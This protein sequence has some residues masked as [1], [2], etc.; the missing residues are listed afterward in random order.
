MFKQ[1]RDDKKAAGRRSGGFAALFAAFVAAAFLVWPVAGLAEAAEIPGVPKSATGLVYLAPDKWLKNAVGKF[2]DVV[3]ADAKFSKVREEFQKNYRFPFPASAAAYVKDIEEIAVALVPEEKGPGII[4]SVLVTVKFG[5]TGTAASFYEKC[6]RRIVDINR[7]PAAG[8]AELA[9]LETVECGV[10][11]TTMVVRD[12]PKPPFVSGSVSPT[13]FFTLVHEDRFGFLF[14]PPKEKE[15]VSELYKSVAG[16]M[17]SGSQ[18][19][20]AAPKFQEAAARI[21]KIAPGF[22]FADGSLIGLPSVAGP[23]SSTRVFSWAAAGM[24][25][26]A[27]DS[28]AVYVRGVFRVDED[29]DRRQAA[30]VAAFKMLFAAQKQG[31]GTLPAALVPRDAVTLLNLRFRVSPETLSLPAFVAFARSF[32]MIPGMNFDSDVASW[33]NGDV[34]ISVDDYAPGAKGLSE[35]PPEVPD[36]AIGFGCSDHQKAGG[37]LD[38]FIATAISSGNAPFSFSSDTIEG[39]KTRCAPLSGIP[40]KNAVLTIGGVGDYFV[41]ASSK[42]AFSRLAAVAAGK[43]VPLSLEKEFK[44]RAFFEK[45]GGKSF[46]ALFINSG[47]L[48]EFGKSLAVTDPALKNQKIN[49]YVRHIYLTVEAAERDL[50]FKFCAT[51]DPAKITSDVLLEKMILLDFI[52]R[53][54]R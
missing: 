35:K 24:G 10:K 37:A 44:N 21:G 46:A 39:I 32:S 4:Y 19:I 49:D 50:A 2:V 29:F 34:F 26:G 48:S 14:S 3:L 54:A 53:P 36:I 20:G 13:P 7:P 31:A 27:D 15:Q 18:N 42:R 45:E 33:F 52:L 43:N 6:S 28:S 12:K 22:L 17:V 23:G 30:E 8:P 5:S 16:S 41:F 25:P 40:C 9:A 1:T 51:F 38:K 47:I 11:V